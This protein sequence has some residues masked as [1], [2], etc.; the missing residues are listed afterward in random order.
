MPQ[1]N[2]IRVLPEI[3]MRRLRKPGFTPAVL[4]HPSGGVDP[5]TAAY[6]FVWNNQL[7]VLALPEFNG[8]E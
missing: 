5:G 8:V 2:R 1:E 7:R 3:P 6:A 4:R